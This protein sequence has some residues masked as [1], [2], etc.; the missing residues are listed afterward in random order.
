MEKEERDAR[1]KANQAALAKLN[2][3]TKPDPAKADALERLRIEYEDHIRQVEGAEPENAGTPLRRF[4][5]EYERLSKQALD[6]ERR[7]IIKLRDEDV[8]NDEVLRR[9]Q[10]DIDLAEARLGQHQS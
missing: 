9:I 3:M 10:R 4:S 8:I 7:T 5:S 6:V 2:E 1:L